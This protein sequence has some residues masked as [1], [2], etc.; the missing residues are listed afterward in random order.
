MCIKDKQVLTKT[1]PANLLAAIVDTSGSKVALVLG[2]GC[3]FE[4]PTD[5]QLS[6]DL[7]EST[8]QNLIEDGI[9]EP[10]DCANPRELSVLADIVFEKQGSQKDMVDRMPLARFQNASPNDGYLIAVALMREQAISCVLTLNFDLAASHALAEMDARTEVVTINGPQESHLLS[11]VNLIYLHRNVYADAEDWILRTAQLDGAWKGGWEGVIAQSV[12]TR[13]NV[14]F[15]GLGSPAGAL[16]ESVR[17][18][19]A[20]T[21][22]CSIYQVD[23][24][25]FSQSTFVEELEI[26]EDHYIKLGW[27]EFMQQLGER[28]AKAQIRE[29]DEACKELEQENGWEEEDCQSI[30][31]SLQDLGLINI[32]R[33]RARWLL[34]SERYVPNRGLI[35][36]HIADL[37]RGL[38][39]LCRS[40]EAEVSINDRGVAI[41][42]K[43]GTPKCTVVLV[44]G[45]GHR[46]YPAIHSSIIGMLRENEYSTHS[47]PILFLVAGISGIRS[48][49]LP[50]ES[51]TTEKD[52]NSIVSGGSVILIYATDEFRQN[53]SLIKE[54]LYDG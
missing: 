13:S 43:H 30:L 34:S 21:T 32:G 44:S 51:I 35:K 52:P 48:E 8:H 17:R 23:P 20:A 41:L 25:E 7:A 16:T 5:L 12:V 46:R 6:P 47:I 9:L 40:A 39:L 3:S 11:A 45:Q 28:V 49:T 22:S 36:K 14:V 1:L 50:P 15:V 54:I 42:F 19:K 27:V 29:L 37:V 18:V 53:E 10:G 4:P 31:K 38:A 33:V 2:A 26:T 24:G